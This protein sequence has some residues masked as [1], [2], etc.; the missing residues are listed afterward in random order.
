MRVLI[1][2]SK[3]SG[4]IAPFI[5]E[6]VEALNHLG[7]ETEYFTIK[8]K[9]VMGYLKSRKSLLKTIADY[10]PDLLHAHFGLSGLLAN[11]Q[12]KIPVVTTYHGSD[13]NNN[14]IFRFSK[15]SIRLSSYN[16]FVSKKNYDKAAKKH[17]KAAVIPCGVDTNTFFQIDKIEARQRMGLDLDEHLV[18]FSSSFKNNVKN[19]ELA[20]AAIQKLGGIRLIELA[21]YSRQEVALLMN[22]VDV[23][24]M[25]SHTEGSP[26]FIKEA[27]AC[28][29]PIVSVKV[30]DVE[31]ML[32]N[33]KNCYI[34]DYDTEDIASKLLLTLKKGERTNGGDKIA[35]MSLYMRNVAERIIYIYKK[36]LY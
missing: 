1:V 36:I 18:L 11:L 32:K 15:W 30:G 20:K 9:G 25:T 22:A 3:N 5:I 12:R 27:M 24:L 8:Q 16:I 7:I 17:L 33:V 4:N 31:E 19:P 26:Q 14:A 29:C 28:G 2:C 13:I 10:K 23:C 35:A 6:Q 21:G 34:A